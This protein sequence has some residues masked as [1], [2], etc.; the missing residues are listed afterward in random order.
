[1]KFEK[2]KNLENVIISVKASIENALQA[3]EKNGLRTVIVADQTSTIVGVLS[4]SDIRR[5]ILKNIELSSNVKVALNSN[6]Y[7]VHI[8]NINNLNTIP[9]HV[10]VVPILDNNRSIISVVRRTT[11]TTSLNSIEDPFLIMAGGKGTRL[12]P[13]TKDIPKPL[14]TIN[15]EP[16]IKIIIDKAKADG[17]RNFIISVNY[18]KEK[19]VEYLGNGEKFGI[20]INY[21]EETR[22]LGTAGSLGLIREHEFKNLF[23]TNCDIITG[24]SY[25]EFYQNHIDQNSHASMAVKNFRLTNPYG[26]VDTTEN[27]L[28]C[29]FTEKPSYESLINTGIYVLN[30]KI[31]KLLGNN[32]YL[33]MPSLFLRAI[34]KGLTCSTYEIFDRWTDV[35]LRAELEDVRNE[36]I[37][38]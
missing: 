23:I 29:G 2:I 27:G 32:E 1:M 18:L 24:S 9:A 10:D 26:V 28:I 30:S 15:N 33:D 12:F 3:I 31:I 4:D 11:E 19:I 21:I 38:K 34:E 14:V 5:A 35:G 6:Y 37:I 25:R 13:L 36:A 17:F 16:M 22:P 8:S 7:S 20:N